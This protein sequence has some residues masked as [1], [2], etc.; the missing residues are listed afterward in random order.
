MYYKLPHVN[1]Q[2]KSLWQH[3]RLSQFSTLNE[4][5]RHSLWFSEEHGMINT[6]GKIVMLL[7]PSGM[8]GEMTDG[9]KHNLQGTRLLRSY[10]KLCKLHSND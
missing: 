6:S 4:S 3:I 2:N 1:E 5:G 9:V 10:T 8:L 7:Q